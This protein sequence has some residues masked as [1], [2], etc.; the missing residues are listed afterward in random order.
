MKK[1]IC[2]CALGIT[3]ALT[4]CTSSTNAVNK[5]DAAV[6]SADISVGSHLNVHNTDE[7][8]TLFSNMDTLSSDG[9][10][11]ASWTA[12]ES[13]PYENTDGDTVDLF[14]AQLYLLLG[15]YQNAESALE[16]MN[17]WL[18]AGQKNYEITDEQEVTC[19]GQTYT[20]ISYQFKNTE[21]PY[22]QGVSAFGVHDNLAV[23]AELTCR[24]QYAEDLYQ[25]LTT[26]LDGCS[27]Q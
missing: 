25:M 18:T 27:Y 2:I 21:S 16:N 17:G 23:C 8:L 13:E 10:Y 6:N 5:A 9:L 11:Y 26:F 22:A 12:G 20:V 14:D 3:L 7:R 24:E 4:G 1:A 15:E 19:N